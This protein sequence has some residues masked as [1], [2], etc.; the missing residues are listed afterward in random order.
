MDRRTFA[1]VVRCVLLS[2][3]ACG[4]WRREHEVLRDAAGVARLTQV[5]LPPYAPWSVAGDVSSGGQNICLRL[6][7]TRQTSLHFGATF[8]GHNLA[9]L[10]NRA[11]LGGKKV[12]PF[13]GSIDCCWSGT[14]TSAKAV[15]DSAV[16][17]V[18]ER[19]ASLA[20]GSGTSHGIKRGYI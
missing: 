7:D 1:C 15:C 18:R 17:N 10:G 3:L 11:G 8:T 16:L 19:I 2:T 12:E 20:F 5:V 4:L 14:T 13:A 9:V 6:V